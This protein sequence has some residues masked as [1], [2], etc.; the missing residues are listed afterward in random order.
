MGFRLRVA[1]AE[2]VPAIRALI[3]DSVRGLQADDYTARQIEGSLKTVFTVDS[4]LIVRGGERGGHFSGATR[5][6]PA[7]G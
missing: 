1:T 7:I 5:G 3:A 2:D 4:Q 6:K